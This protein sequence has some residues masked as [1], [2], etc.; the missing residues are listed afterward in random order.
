MLLM[1]YSLSL[2]LQVTDNQRG[3]II[4]NNQTFLNS[5]APRD[6]WEEASTASAEHASLQIAIHVSQGNCGTAQGSLAP[7][8]CLWAKAASGQ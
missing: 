5:E 4:G 2:S 7:F 3:R 6:L 1:P 8:K